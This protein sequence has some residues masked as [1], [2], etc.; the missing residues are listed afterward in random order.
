MAFG[1][2]ADRIKDNLMLAKPT[3]ILAVPR[4]F[5]KIHSGL[6]HQI[7]N[8]PMK[9][10]I[11]EWAVQVGVKVVK[12]RHKRQ[13]LSLKLASQYLLAKKLVFNKILE[14]LGGELTRA[15]C[16]GAGL[17]PKMS[18][19]FEAVGVTIFE[20]YGMTETTAAVTVNTPKFYQPGSVGK[21][22]GDTKIR[23]ADDGEILV[24]GSL[25][26]AGYYQ[27]AEST[28]KT[29]QDS[30]LHTGDIGELSSDGF[31]RITD[32][33]KDLIKTSNGKY[34]APQ[35]I[36]SMLK[37]HNLISQVHIVGHSRKH[38]GALITLN[39]EQVRVADKAVRSQIADIIHQV[40]SRL[41]DHEFIKEYKILSQDF[42]VESGEIT[43]SM[44]IRKSVVETKYKKE[45]DSLYTSA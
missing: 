16:G 22:I 43:P 27:D 3:I 32:R 30:W 5:E 15:V 26:M 14:K 44:K 18:L 24:K 36:E 12:Q 31:L 40:N 38:I 20:G 13:F 37:T 1:V 9:K 28:A 34:V 21:P 23:I 7:E 2:D 6:L 35:K 8:Q 4:L 29:V 17:D 39:P 45:I 19:F 33:K 25:V 11:F 42:T 10:M 41:G